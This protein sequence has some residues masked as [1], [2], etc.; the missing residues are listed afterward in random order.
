MTKIIMTEKQKKYEKEMLRVINE[1][2][3][4]FFDHC[5][6]FTTF[7]AATAYNHN[8]EKLESIKNAIAG[9]RVKAKNYMLNKWIASDNPTLQI[10]AM[11]LLSTPE[12]HQKLNQSYID[13]TSKGE[14]INILDLGSGKSD[15]TT[16]T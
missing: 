14:K 10:A 1:K 12:E 13:H 11:R 15:E 8:L 2:K 16:T 5:F 6:A 3:I 9:N 7:S 4:A